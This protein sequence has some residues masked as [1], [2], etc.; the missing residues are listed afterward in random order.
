M[1]L[2]LTMLAFAC[3]AWVRQYQYNM[4]HTYAITY[5]FGNGH[6]FIIY[7]PLYAELDPILQESVQVHEDR[8]LEQGSY[9]F[10]RHNELE[11]DAYKFQIA[12]L[13]ERISQFEELYRNNPSYEHAKTLHLLREFKIGML[14]HMRQYQGLEPPDEGD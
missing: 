11:I 12:K 8:H 1:T 5:S 9:A 7:S 3:A 10:W 4:S 14:H 6:G 13:D 2:L